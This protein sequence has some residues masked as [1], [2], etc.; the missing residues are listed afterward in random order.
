MADFRYP[1]PLQKY[2][3]NRGLGTSKNYA[4]LIDDINFS[5]A[6]PSSVV[7]ILQGDIGDVFG[8]IVNSVTT[9]GIGEVGAGSQR[10]ATSV[11]TGDSAPLAFPGNVTAGNLLICAGRAASFTSSTSVAVTDTLGTTYT[12]ISLAVNANEVQW[13]AYGIS[14]SSGANTVTANPSSADDQISFAI[15][16]FTG[17]DTTTPLS[18]NGGSSTGTSTAP[19]DSITTLTNGELIIGVMGYAGADATITPTQT[20]LGENENNTTLQ[21]YAAS[22]QISGVA[23]GYSMSWTLGGSRTWDVL[24]ASFKPVSTGTTVVLQGDIGGLNGSVVANTATNAL[25]QGA[26]GGLNGSLVANVSEDIVLQ[27]GIGEI[28]GALV[29]NVSVNALLQGDVGEISGTINAG[30]QSP[31]AILQGVLDDISGSISASTATDVSLTGDVG[32]ISGAI[33]A[34]TPSLDLV[35]QG[36]LD[37]V[38]GQLQATVVTSLLL[39]GDVGSLT[40]SINSSTATDIT[41]VGNVGDVSGVINTSALD[42]LA[43]SLGGS[44]D[45]ISGILDATVTDEAPVVDKDK[46]ISGKKHVTY[47]KGKKQKEVLKLR[48]EEIDQQVYNLLFNEAKEVLQDAN[49]QASSV[50]VLADSV[51]SDVLDRF[52]ANQVEAEKERVLEEARLNA[53]LVAVE[54]LNR[55]YREDEELLLLL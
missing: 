3:F 52:N 35:L 16:E 1:F 48:P 51:V 43:I 31:D 40:G 42:P 28:S 34:G 11:G 26:V 6:P 39:G 7:A 55:L 32:G 18:V 37:D 22:Y 44:L 14:P 27:G 25:L 50:D 41:I 46:G 2:L 9:I 45:D 54:Y 23:G 20:Q 49:V 10:A 15:D 47:I 21:A 19:S 17:V 33:N 5:A 53:Y 30:L 36:T 4:A 38:S 12:V 8:N 13:I 24:T 29:A